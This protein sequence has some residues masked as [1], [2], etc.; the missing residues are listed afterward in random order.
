MNDIFLSKSIE[1]S[2][3]DHGNLLLDFII[4]DFETNKNGKKINRE[5]IDNWLPTLINQPLVGRVSKISNTDEFDF[6]SHNKKVK[7][8]LEDGKLNTKTI[9][10]TD[11]IGTFLSAE[12]KTIEGKDY[13]T[14]QALMW[15]RFENAKSVILN[16]IANNEPLCSSWE[17]CITDSISSIENGQSVEIINNGYYIGHCLL[18]RR[19]VDGTVVNPA[20]ECSRVT[21]LQVAEEDLDELSQAIDKDRQ[22][23]QSEQESEEDKLNKKGGEEMAE[24]NKNIETSALTMNDISK[25]LRNIVWEIEKE[26][27]TNWY[28]LELVYP[29][30]NIAY[31]KRCGDNALDEDFLKVSYSIDD[32]GDISVVSKEEVKMVF[33]P[34]ESQV[35]VSEIE[36]KLKGIEAELS[37]KVGDIVKLGETIKANESIIAERDKTIAELEVFKSQIEEIQAEQ[38]KQEIAEKQ[39]ELK[40]RAISS[41]YITEEFIETSERL[42]KAISE[43]NEDEVLKCVAEEVIK[44]NTQKQVE[45]SSEEIEVSETDDVDISTDLSSTDEY[46]Y[47]DSDSNPILGILSK[48]KKR[49]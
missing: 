28:Y 6:T 49:R 12:V 45:S 31:L 4:C 25:K 7:Y 46:E 1:V 16:K 21:D 32:N 47:N 10:D 17:L 22:V 23:I 24:E 35:D 18:G 15:G 37:E 39:E 48:N 27:Y 2:E 30:E 5:T 26:D 19:P 43:L 33:V 3:D 38:A 14:A 40:K 20:Y 29:T 8:V 41:G 42:Q 11:A 13:I 34:K 9:L 36:E 44:T